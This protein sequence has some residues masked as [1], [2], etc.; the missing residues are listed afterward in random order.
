MKKGE[1]NSKNVFVKMKQGKIY[2]I[3]DLS[4]LSIG[5]CG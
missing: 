2:I 1:I 3:V 5:S 4:I